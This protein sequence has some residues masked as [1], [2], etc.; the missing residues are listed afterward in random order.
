MNHLQTIV[1]PSSDCASKWGLLCYEWSPA[2]G[3]GGISD[4]LQTTEYMNATLEKKA[5]AAAKKAAAAAPTIEAAAAIVEAAAAAPAPTLPDVV[6]GA[7]A[8]AAARELATFEA[9]LPAPLSAKQRAALF[10]AAANEAAALVTS[11]L[12]KDGENLPD[13]Y[14]VRKK[15]GKVI[16]Q[17]QGP[18]VIAAIRGAEERTWNVGKGGSA[19]AHQFKGFLGPVLVPD[20]ATAREK[21]VASGVNRALAP[22]HGFPARVIRFT[23]KKGVGYAAFVTI[24]GR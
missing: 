8:M 13:V 1:L 9:A 20:D 10:K 22:F 24:M 23:G 3:S 11:A 16:D 5:A 2:G 19:R 6:T 7:V 4:K 21:A 17:L 12:S 14:G 18:L 15:G